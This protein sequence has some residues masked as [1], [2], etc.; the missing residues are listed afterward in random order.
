MVL[1]DETGPDREPSPRFSIVC[2]RRHCR[3]G[4]VRGADPPSGFISDLVNLVGACAQEK[5]K[6]AP[7][8][9][10][11]V[12]RRVKPVDGQRQAFSDFREASAAAT[13]TMAAGCPATMSRDPTARLDEAARGFAT[14]MRAADIAAPAVRTFY[15]QLDDEQKA[16]I[17]GSSPHDTAD[18][19]DMLVR[20]C[21][22][23]PSIE[24]LRKLSL[25][26]TQRKA[27]EQ[28]RESV[29]AAAGRLK[30][31]CPPNDLLTP[32]R[33]LEAM[34][35]RAEALLRFVQS[36]RSDLDRFYVTLDDRQRV[37]TG[38]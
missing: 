11:E 16:R 19:A 15:A 20:I 10:Q 33:R 21:T 7:A 37:M 29:E 27:F 34:R 13:E 9:A 36:I 4:R 28:A 14:I 8:V 2:G 32:P 12:E 23:P 6:F 1:P 38:D 30:T 5:A 18:D 26:D 3:I 24:T 31:A 25:T 35:Q 17:S 22:T